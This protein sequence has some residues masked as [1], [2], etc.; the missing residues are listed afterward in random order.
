VA[1]CPRAAPRAGR[2]DRQFES[3]SLRRRVCLTGELRGYRRRGPAF[4]ADVTQSMSRKGNCWD[5]APV[6]SFFGTHQGRS[7]WL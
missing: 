5:N 3:L 4:A 7:P 6:E 2:R 1:Q